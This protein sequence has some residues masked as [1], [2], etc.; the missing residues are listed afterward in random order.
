MCD[1]TN[2]NKSINFSVSKIYHFSGEKIESF[3]HYNLILNLMDS[4][5]KVEQLILNGNDIGCCS[6]NI[7]LMLILN[8]LLSLFQFLKVFHLSDCK[9]ILNDYDSEDT[10]FNETSWKKFLNTL[11]GKINHFY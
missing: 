5:Q 10:T 4:F 2:S 11:K 3:H 8:N 9:I 6:T 1:L 7:D